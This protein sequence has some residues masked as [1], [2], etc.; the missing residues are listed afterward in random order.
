MEG[1]SN[2]ERQIVMLLPVV[3]QLPGGAG[4]GQLR[5]TGKYTIICL[6]SRLAGSVT[7]NTAFSTVVS[8]GKFVLFQ[9]SAGCGQVAHAGRPAVSAP[10]CAAR[11]MV[12]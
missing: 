2:T 3:T 11:V 8:P 7:E 10:C 4:R 5:T 6:R 12:E 9:L 1:F